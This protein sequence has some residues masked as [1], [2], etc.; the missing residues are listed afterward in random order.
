MELSRIERVHETRFFPNL[1]LFIIRLG[2]SEA[3]DSSALAASSRLFARSSAL[4][5]PCSI[6]TLDAS[7]IQISR[8]GNF[9]LISAI[10]YKCTSPQFDTDLTHQIFLIYQIS[11]F[12]LV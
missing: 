4:Q 6:L 3:H 5:L 9:S 2:K 1:L 7:G 12:R 10:D 11:Q 8:G